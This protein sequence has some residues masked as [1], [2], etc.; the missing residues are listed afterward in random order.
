MS[1]D[2]RLDAPAT[3]HHVRV[4][5]KESRAICRDDQDRD[6]VLR[7]VAAVAGATGLARD[8][9]TLW[10]KQLRLLGQIRR[11]RQRATPKESGVLRNGVPPR[12]LE[13]EVRAKPKG[14]LRGAVAFMP[15]VLF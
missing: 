3:L 7:R 2:P 15:V 11:N 8:A 1:R 14:H 9:C 5:G 13:G 4:R 12:P 10:S 6:G